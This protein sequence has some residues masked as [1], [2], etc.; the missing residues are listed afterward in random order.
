M[1]LLY[2]IISLYVIIT[3]RCLL[4]EAPHQF[5]YSPYSIVVFKCP[6]LHFHHI[7]VT[8]RL[9][10]GLLISARI[11]NNQQAR[12]QVLW[13]DLICQSAWH[14]TVTWLVE[15]CGTR[16]Q[17]IHYIKQSNCVKKHATLMNMTTLPLWVCMLLGMVLSNIT[18]IT[19]L[20]I[21]VLLTC[22]Y[23]V[24]FSQKR[25]DCH[26]ET[27]GQV[28]NS[29]LLHHVEP[30][31]RPVGS[32]ANW[33]LDRLDGCKCQPET[34][35]RWLDDPS[36]IN[37]Y[38]LFTRMEKMHWFLVHIVT[39]HKSIYNGSMC[40]TCKSTCRGWQQ[41]N[42]KPGIHRPAKGLALVYWPKP[43]RMD[44]GIKWIPLSSCFG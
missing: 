29:V 7:G 26:K 19:T 37:I 16:S 8:G 5:T 38:M 13:G 34:M 17:R 36:R 11:C 28:Y 24:S 23:V 22:H 20:C 35:T 27:L 25:V 4:N 1:P 31:F 21:T 6:P 41:P 44:S 9:L 30:L 15:S 12:L 2:A 40:S 39:N 33:T 14:L 3:S 10:D 42:S 43:R 32:T 18:K